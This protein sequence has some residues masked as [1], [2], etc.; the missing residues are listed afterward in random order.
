[1]SSVNICSALELKSNLHQS[2]KSE[3]W[4]TFILRFLHA[5]NGSECL[6]LYHFV[7]WSLNSN[8]TDHSPLHGYGLCP[9]L[10]LLHHGTLS[11]LRGLSCTLR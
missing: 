1:M 2:T 5:F 8:K 4:T 3:R 10:L 11:F 6:T 7:R 9:L